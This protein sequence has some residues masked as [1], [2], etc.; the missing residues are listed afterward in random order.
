MYQQRSNK[1]NRQ[2]DKKSVVQSVVS[3]EVKEK[4]KVQLPKHESLN[5]FV[6]SHVNFSSIARTNVVLED[7]SIPTVVSVSVSQPVSF[8]QNTEK[9]NTEKTQTDEFQTVTKRRS[10]DRQNRIKQQQQQVQRPRSD[11]LIVEGFDDI[12]QGE[13]NKYFAFYGELKQFNFVQKRLFVSYTTT[14]DAYAAWKHIREN[15]QYKL[16]IRFWYN[17]EQ[18]QMRVQNFQN[19]YKQQATPRRQYNRQYNN[20][21][22]KQQQQQ[23]EEDKQYEREKQQRE[24]KRKLLSFRKTDWF[25]PKCKTLNFSERTKC[26]K[27][28]QERIIPREVLDAEKQLANERAARRAAEKQEQQ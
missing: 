4:P 2:T 17:K 21:R 13:M 15:N 3:T 7:D 9:Q 16:N 1:K 23:T 14:D 26:L 20:D 11:T 10:N 24:A 27:C 18:Q 12:D 28:S 25:C 6:S 19:G 5:K 22:S 8:V